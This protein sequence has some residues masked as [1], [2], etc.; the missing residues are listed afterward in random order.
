MPTQSVD[1]GRVLDEGSWSAHQ[2]LV[3]FLTALAIVFDGLDNQ[4]LGIAVPAMMREWNVARGAFA[5]VLAAGMLGMMIGGAVAGVM[6]DRVGRR[7][8]LIGSVVTFGALTLAVAAADTLLSLGVLRFVAGLGLGGALP[9][10]AALAS[11]YVPRRYRALAVTLT[12][13]CV[14]LGGTLGALLGGRILPVLGWRALFVIGGL[15]PLA[16]AALLIRYLPESPRYLAR[17]PERWPELAAVLRRA[18]HDVPSTASFSDATESGVARVSLA[19][20]FGADLRRDT[21]ALWGAFLSCL[22][23]VYLGFNWIP[24]MLSG[25]GLS[26]RTAST[27]LAAFNLGG[28]AGA[29]A[30]GWLIAR[31]GS[32]VTM[33]TMTAGAVAGSLVL[34][35]LPVRPDSAGPIVAMLGVTGGL[36]NAVQTTMYALAAN[37]YPTAVRATGVGAAVSFGRT[38]AVLSTYAG[39]WALEAGGSA[40]FFGLMAGSLTLAFL[41][42]ALVRRHVPRAT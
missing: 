21:V 40:A 18:G 6:G 25:G 10:A 7:I 8:A 38:G 27:A 13:V 4:L 5:P 11:E 19:A 14:P 28:V 32:R 31:L 35:M 17:R 34:S 20:L 23:A 15:V 3:V 24:A 30:G 36:I 42:L 39:A 12:I 26:L 16:V 9:N 1:V 37:V 22:L 2:K 41:S 33:L 29:I